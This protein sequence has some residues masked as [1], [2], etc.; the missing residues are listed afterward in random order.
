[1][2]AQ[3]ANMVGLSDILQRTWQGRGPLA[4]LLLLPGCIFLLVAVL[5]RALYRL[6][7]LHSERLPVPVVMVGNIIVGGS[8]KTP[9]TLWLAQ[10]MLERNWHPGIVSRGY[11]GS[12][13]AGVVRE[14]L[15]DS[16]TLEM[17]DEPLLLKRRSGLPVFVGSDRVAA[18]RSLLAIYPDCDLII[19]DDGMQHYRLQRDVEIALLD[20]RGLMNGWPLPAGPLR[21]PAS[22]LARVDAIVSNGESNLPICPAPVFSMKLTG[23]MFY[24]LSDPKQTCTTATLKPL[25]LAAIAGMGMPQR[26]FQHLRALGLR[27][28]EHAFPDHHR[29]DAADLAAIQADALLV[30]EKD[31]VKCAGLTERPVWVLPVTAQVAPAAA[32]IDLAAHVEYC[33]REKMHGRPPA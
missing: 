10:Q 6:G 18:A 7:I 22:R 31:A 23:D 33:I 11:A 1:M 26:F 2:R 14:V 29:Y 20:G 13:P 30:T 32:G 12:L 3:A 27:F 25:R 19:S 9:L 21:E 8:G 4:W 28:S 24:L 16:N 15:A 17:G 5:R